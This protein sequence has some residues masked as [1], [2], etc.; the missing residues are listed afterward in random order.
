MTRVRC[1]YKGTRISIT[2]TNDSGVDRN[3]HRRPTRHQTDGL[4]GAWPR[5]DVCA[6]SK[7]TRRGVT[8]SSAEHHHRAQHIKESPVMR[9]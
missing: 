1:S 7:E 5:P 6:S 3:L 4:E 9:S 2:E 8:E